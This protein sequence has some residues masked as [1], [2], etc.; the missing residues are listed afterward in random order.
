[1]FKQKVHFILFKPGCF[2]T[3]PYV[4]QITDLSGDTNAQIT[5]SQK[6]VYGKCWYSLTKLFLCFYHRRL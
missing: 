1:M 3:A 2:D 6:E 5:I 4:W